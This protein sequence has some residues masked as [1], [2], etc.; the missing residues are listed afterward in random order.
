MKNYFTIFALFYSVFFIVQEGAID[1]NAHDELSKKP[2]ESRL[3]I[4]ETE[5]SFKGSN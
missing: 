1:V 2:L 5:V 4:P 3:P